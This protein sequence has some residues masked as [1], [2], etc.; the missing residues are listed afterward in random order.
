M[1]NLLDFRAHSLCFPIWVFF[2]WISQGMLSVAEIP[3]TWQGW[4]HGCS[5]SASC[6]VRVGTAT[7]EPPWRVL[8]TKSKSKLLEGC[9]PTVEKKKLKIL[10]L[11]HILSMQCI[12]LLND[13]VVE[14]LPHPQDPWNE[15]CFPGLQTLTLFYLFYLFLLFLVP[16]WLEH[17]LSFP[18]RKCLIFHNWRRRIKSNVIIL[19]GRSVIVKVLSTNCP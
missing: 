13:S 8:Q 15:A 16:L 7:S 18:Q 17:L 2:G 10:R 6:S 1:E 12:F 14:R 3:D 5:S 19:I 11:N 4:A 9:V